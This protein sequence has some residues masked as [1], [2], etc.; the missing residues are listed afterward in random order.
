MKYF[1]LIASITLATTTVVAYENHLSVTS[2]GEKVNRIAAMGH[3]NAFEF[4][5]RLRANKKVP[6]KT[7][8]ADDC[9]EGKDEGGQD[10]EGGEE[11]GEEEEEEEEEGEEEEEEEE[12]EGSSEGKSENVDGTKKGK[13]K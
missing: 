12:E 4:T 2:D 10:E 1:A 5:R 6:K 8:D 7:N 13:A 3:G 9:E 11:E